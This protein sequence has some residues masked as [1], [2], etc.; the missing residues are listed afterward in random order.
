MS[1]ASL[2][3]DNY[4]R[5]AR[6]RPALLVALPAIMGI[7]SCFPSFTV[8]YALLAILIACG[9][10]ALVAQLGRDRGK[11]LEPR[12]FALWG[13]K[14]T[15]QLLRHSTKHLPDATRERYHNKLQALVPGIVL[16]S[17]LLEGIEPA[18][19]DSVYD[20]CAQF[21]REKT[22]DNSKYPLLYS[23]NV[24]YGFR[25]NLWAMKPTGIAFGLAGL[26]VSGVAAIAGIKDG[27]VPAVPAAAVLIDALLLAFW[28]LRITP[29]W[30]RLTAFA[31]AER[32]LAVCDTIESRT[33][34]V[35]LN[36]S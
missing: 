12:L 3:C 15:T 21:L 2:L 35:S 4:E 19:A 8:S 32:L 1:I 23:E 22:R 11:V 7:V 25:R 31:Y 16:P 9:A 5:R 33:A 10:V 29:S 18:A 34:E 6:L 14:P 27:V 26:V 17:R 20:S 36:Q 24:S 13:G 28:M 30:V